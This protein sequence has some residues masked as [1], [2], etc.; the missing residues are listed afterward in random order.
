MRCFHIEMVDVIKKKRQTIK[1]K[2][3]KAATDLSFP[4]VIR[5]FIG[6]QT[7]VKV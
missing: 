1:I 4:V 5:I 2:I 6:L 7:S 3:I